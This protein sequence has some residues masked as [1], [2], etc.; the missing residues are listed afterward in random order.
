MLEGK[1]RSW[2]Q[3]GSLLSIQIGFE[4]RPDRCFGFTKTYI[5]TNQP[6]HG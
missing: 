1:D 3:D 6:V 5:A 2:Y 4:G